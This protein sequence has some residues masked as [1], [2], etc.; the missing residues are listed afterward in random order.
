[1]LQSG[2]RFIGCQKDIGARYMLR[3]WNYTE[4]SKEDLQ[5]LL[6]SFN[7]HA[8]EG[9]AELEQVSLSVKLASYRQDH[10]EGST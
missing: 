3:G 5:L 1:M 4:R 2:C 6:L 10:V 9:L 8:H 7:L